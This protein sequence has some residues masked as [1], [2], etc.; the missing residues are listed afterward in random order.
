MKSSLLM[1]LC[2]K[3]ETHPMAPNMFFSLSSAN[4]TAAVQFPRASSPLSWKSS[5]ALPSSLHKGNLRSGTFSAANT[6][7]QGHLHPLSPTQNFTFLPFLPT[8][9]ISRHQKRPFMID[10]GKWQV[11]H[12]P[13]SAPIC[14]RK[15]AVLA[16]ITLHFK[17]RY[18]TLD[19]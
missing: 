4:T 17:A 7:K 11:T 19:I 16:L 15:R 14:F 2:L 1:L 5:P 13:P 12:H 10:G 9:P 3:G 18:L 8:H 6:S